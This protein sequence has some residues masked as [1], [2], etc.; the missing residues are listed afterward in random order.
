MVQH[1]LWLRNE[2]LVAG[3]GV[4]VR[5][6]RPTRPGVMGKFLALLPSRWA[7]PELTWGKQVSQ[8]ITAN[9]ICQG[10]RFSFKTFFGEF[11]NTEEKV[12]LA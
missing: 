10:N 3:S 1:P 7:V 11:L 5:N 8:G 6:L 9:E 2:E 4:N 12:A